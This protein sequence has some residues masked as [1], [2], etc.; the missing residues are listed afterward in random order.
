MEKDRNVLRNLSAVVPGR[1][2]VQKDTKAASQ[3]KLSCR[4]RRA[5]RPWSVSAHF[6]VPQK[7]DPPNGQRL[8]K[9]VFINRK[10]SLLEFRRTD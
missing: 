10:Q 4:C 9:E 1:L 6:L 3:V 2:V 5:Y 7:S 8:S